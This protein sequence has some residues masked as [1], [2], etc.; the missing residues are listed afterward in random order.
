MRRL[1]DIRIG[2]RNIEVT[3]RVIDITR[4]TVNV[5]NNE[6]TVFS[7][8][9]RDETAARSFTAWEDFGINAG[10][11]IRVTQAYVKNWQERPEVNFGTRS[12]VIKLPADTA[13]FQEIELKKLSELR[14][15]EVNVYT[16]FTI[17]KI[18]PREI[19]T[20]DGTRHILSGIAAD[21][22]TKLP[23]TS[24]VV[25]PEL[26]AGNS[27]KVENAYVRSFRGVPTIH[28]N[29]NSRVTTLDKRIDYTEPER[30]LIGDI[31]MKD[32]A[33]DI[34][35]EGN[36]L[37]VRPGSG[38]ISRCT[39]CNRV[40]QKGMCRVHG[41][42]DEKLDMRVK[43]IVDDGTGALML[44]LDAQLTQEICGITIEEAKQMAKTAMSPEAV[45]EH[46]KRKL[47]GRTLTARGNMSKGEFGVMLVAG[48]VWEPKDTIIEKADYLLEK[49]G[50]HGKDN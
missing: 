8:I 26:V 16:A 4:K 36:I 24:W 2:D 27:I 49:A 6:K 43:A 42:V 17:M 31:I 45:E 50:Y 33:F 28:I 5:K 47:I 34:M 20:K 7:G 32:G 44:V 35:I 15:G 14:D 29:E 48:K 30:V 23:F 18:D 13:L 39:V 46:I 12:K 10:D 40:M 22:N 37:S 25:L 21:G 38:L 19:I 9:L 41:K 1:D 3:G 11:V